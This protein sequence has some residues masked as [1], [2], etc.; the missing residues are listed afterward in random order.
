MKKFKL[1]DI[2]GIIGSLIWV[3]AVYGRYSSLMTNESINFIIG[4]APNLGALWFFAFL[5]ESLYTSF[6]KKEYTFK[7]TIITLVGLCVLAITSE[8]IHDLF[9]GSPFDT[10]DI[11][12]TL[13]SA[14]IYAVLVK[15]NEK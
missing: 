4:I 8:I 10:Y 13:I 9:L 11:I 2:L 15:I 6:F 7:L 12:A 1:T 3:L 5:I 14:T